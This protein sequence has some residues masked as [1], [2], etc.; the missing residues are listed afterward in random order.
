MKKVLLTLMVLGLTQMAA[1]K[2]GGNTP[3][4]LNFKN[5]QAGFVAESLE[6]SLRLFVTTNDAM[7]DL[8]QDASIVSETPDSSVV[9]LSLS[10]GS[11]VTYTC[12]RMDHWSQGGTVLKKEVI[13]AAQ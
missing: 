12:N 7:K 9:T 1:A 11:A 5:S 10:D 4:K 2:G 13:C 8:V 6:H 3:E